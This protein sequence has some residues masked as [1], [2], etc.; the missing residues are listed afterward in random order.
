MQ[1][2][3]ILGR[4]D[5]LVSYN[6]RSRLC[7]ESSGCARVYRDT[8]ILWEKCVNANNLNMQVRW[9]NFQIKLI[10]KRVFRAQP[11]N[12]MVI[13]DPERKPVW[14]TKTDRKGKAFGSMELSDDGKL[15][16]YDR[17]R[18]RLWGS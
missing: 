7:V 11:D 6:G 13:Y 18:V 17:K 4:G 14:Q 16:V 5:C 3:N 9:G 2:Y 12:N 8:K 1:S 10:V 15:V